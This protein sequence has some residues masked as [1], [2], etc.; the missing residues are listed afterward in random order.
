[1]HKAERQTDIGKHTRYAVFMQGHKNQGNLKQINNYDSKFEC[2]GR[3]ATS[4]HLGIMMQMTM[5]ASSSLESISIGVSGVF[6][7]QT[8]EALS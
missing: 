5:H 6:S 3:G 8:Y 2:A 4:D 1:M 7:I